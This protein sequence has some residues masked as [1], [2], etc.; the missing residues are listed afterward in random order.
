MNSVLDRK[1]VEK[2]IT[3]RISVPNCGNV[4]VTLNYRE[5][6]RKKIPV[7]IF[8]RLG[9]SGGCQ[10]AFFDVVGRLISFYLQLG[11]PVRDVM[12]K[13]RGTSC[14]YSPCCIDEV[15]KFVMDFLEGDEA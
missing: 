6:G 9:K 10:H 2:G 4:Y 15:S 8:I 13:L 14:P 11:L 3:K 1:D 5:N 7:E 12:M